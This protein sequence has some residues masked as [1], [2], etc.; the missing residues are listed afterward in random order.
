MNRRG[1][2]DAFEQSTHY[3][4]WIYKKDELRRIR[5]QGLRDGIEGVKAAIKKQQV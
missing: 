3:Q 2:A 5:E 1:I 4:N